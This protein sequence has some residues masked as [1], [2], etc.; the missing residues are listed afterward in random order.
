MRREVLEEKMQNKR[1]N[2]YESLPAG[3]R[4]DL[5]PDNIDG[6][7]MER[8]SSGVPI[9]VSSSFIDN[10]NTS[11]SHHQPI[12]STQA[13]CAQR[14]CRVPR[15]NCY[16]SSKVLHPQAWLQVRTRLTLA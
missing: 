10:F 8:K 4:K 11:Q 12:S 7:G 9:E 3:G 13:G 2:M 6:A 15:Q 14:G 16:N 5:S 1:W